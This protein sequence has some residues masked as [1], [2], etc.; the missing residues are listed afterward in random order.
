MKFYTIIFFL[1][2]FLITAGSAVA[3]TATQ[4]EGKE[5]SKHYLYEWTDDKGTVH[6]SDNLGDVPE[7][8]RR[9]V[10]KRLQQPV[11]EETGRQEQVAPQLAPQTEEETD[12]EARKEEWQQRIRDWKERLADAEKRYK[13]LEYERST[14]TMTGGM[15]TYAP[16]ASRARADEL[17][18]EM[19]Q[20]QKEIDEARNMINVVIPDEALKAGVPPGWLRE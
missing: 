8:Y 11:K 16:P 4:Q 17:K 2:S 12:Q 20:V 9:Q 5:K 7:K 1:L 18:E 14:I 15:T 13:A 10:R 3:Q 19:R 6:I